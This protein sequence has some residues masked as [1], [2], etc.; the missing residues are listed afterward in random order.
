MVSVYSI[1]FLELHA[2]GVLPIA[3][4]LSLKHLIK[5]KNFPKFGTSG[6]ETCIRRLR[7]LDKI[8]IAIEE[9]WLVAVSVC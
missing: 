9:I 4:V 2:R 1:F 7:Y 5:S 3:K 8:L 6:L